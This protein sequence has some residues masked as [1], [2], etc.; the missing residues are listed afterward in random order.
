MSPSEAINKQAARAKS[1]RHSHPSTLHLWSPRRPLTAAWADSFARLVEEPSVRA[2][3]FSTENEQRTERGRLD[4]FIERHCSLGQRM[5]RQVARG[6]AC[7]DP[8]VQCQE[9]VE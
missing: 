6:G 4:G 9:D 2:V 1:I 8:E 7:R 5:R 3:G